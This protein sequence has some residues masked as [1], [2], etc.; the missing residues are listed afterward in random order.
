MKKEDLYI[1]D[2]LGQIERVDTPPFLFTRIEAKIDAEAQPIHS[3]WS[4]ALVAMGVLT[5]MLNIFVVLNS[6]DTDLENSNAS[7]IAMSLDINPSYQ[8]Y[9]D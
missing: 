9:N 2:L 8:L 1:E 6:N 5:I 7:S 4:M 3:Q